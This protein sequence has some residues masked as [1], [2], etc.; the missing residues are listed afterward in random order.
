MQGLA[1]IAPETWQQIVRQ[2]VPLE[3]ANAAVRLIVVTGT[4]TTCESVE[5]LQL[6]TDDFGFLLNWDT[7][8]TQELPPLLPSP[9]SSHSPSQNPQRVLEQ[10]P[11]RTTHRTEDSSRAAT[12]NTINPRKDGKVIDSRHRFMRRYLAHHYS[13]TPSTPLIAEA[14]IRCGYSADV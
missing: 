12:S 4:T 14:L 5:A 1:Q 6:Q 13:W 8:V 7:S 3:P 10:V 2:L 9:S 11:E